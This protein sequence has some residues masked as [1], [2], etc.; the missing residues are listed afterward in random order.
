MSEKLPPRY[1]LR[2]P[3]DNC[4]FRADRPFFLREEVVDGIADDLKRGGTFWCHKTVDYSDSDGAVANKTRVCAG[5][6]ATQAND[7]IVSQAEQITERLIEPVQKLRDGLPV[8]GSVDEWRRA[9]K[10]HS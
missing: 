4:P 10:E 3:C 8:Y 6:R 5:S 1:T 7:G 2:E 9:M